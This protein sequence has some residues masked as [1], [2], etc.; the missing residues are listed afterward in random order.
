MLEL[1]EFNPQKSNKSLSNVSHH[2][3]F[4][5]TTS[6]PFSRKSVAPSTLSGES[7]RAST[8]SA[9]SDHRIENNV[10]IPEKFS[11]EN[12]QPISSVSNLNNSQFIHR[13]SIFINNGN[14]H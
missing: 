12:Q 11:V 1:S 8:S 5:S 10:F 6:S 3:H 9:S 13:H 2:V 7:V 4:Q 14:F